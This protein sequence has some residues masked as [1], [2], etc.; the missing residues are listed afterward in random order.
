MKEKTKKYLRNLGIAYLFA[1][2]G[3]TFKFCRNDKINDFYTLTN[4]TLSSGDVEIYDEDLNI[5]GNLKYENSTDKFLLSIKGEKFSWD[6][7]YLEIN[8]KIEYLEYPTF[9]NSIIYENLPLTL[10]QY[11]DD[12]YYFYDTG[13]SVI[14]VCLLRSWFINHKP[15]KNLSLIENKYGFKKEKQVFMFVESN[16]DLYNFALKYPKP[17]LQEYFLSE[18]ASDVFYRCFFVQEE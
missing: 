5:V 9:Y 8:G 14:L 17:T 4:E 18:R 12:N 7:E 2:L 16:Y 13:K 6:P 3:L 1:I 11:G 10:K 15:I